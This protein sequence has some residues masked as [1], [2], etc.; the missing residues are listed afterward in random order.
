MT[1]APP[2]PLLLS[3]I[4]LPKVWG[5]RRLVAFNKPIPAGENIGE[6]W[7][8]AD[9]GST[10][11]SG[12]GGGAAVSV[13]ANGPLA[14]RSLNDA[15]RLWGEGLLGR[16]APAR[17]P[18]G[19]PR[20]PL[21]VKFL[22]A[23]ESLSVQVHPSPAYARAHPEAHLKTECWYILDA[24]PDSM[25]YKGVKPRVTRESFE[26][27]LRQ[28][29]AAAVLDDLGAFP[30]V[31]GEMHNLPSG[32]VHAL[33]AGVLVAEVQTP[34]D[35]TF[36]VYDWGR[37][38]RELHID[39]A[40][41]C[42]HF[43]PA[44]DASSLAAGARSGRLV[45]TGFFTVDEVRPERGEPLA[46]GESGRCEAW[47]MIEGECRIGSTVDSF[48]PLPAS[49]GATVLVPGACL[50]QMTIESS[51]TARALRVEVM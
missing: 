23:R 3:P 50:A 29:D 36:R 31:P 24:A 32:T 6:S 22:D 17:G 33:G 38:G 35:T 14:G 41:E 5:G 27:H 1:D 9:L 44:R 37:T 51:G 25:I 10:S 11:A 39:E 2:Y 18:A 12:A 13:I 46:P 4:L 30:A 19:E 42:I 7:E 45:S 8:L 34:S 43:G 47:I 16:S 49:K 15:L 26:E 40:L 48:G 20:F 28:G 21:L